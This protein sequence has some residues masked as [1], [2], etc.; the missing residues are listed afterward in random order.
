MSIVVSGSIASDHLMEFPGSFR[1]QLVE[2]HLEQISLSFL[3]DELTIRRGGIGANI[4]FGLG[5]LGLRP[6]LVGSVGSDFEDYREWLEQHGV[7]TRAVHVSD[8]RH[9]ARFLCTTD[10]DGNQIASFY[11]GAMTEAS[12][13]DL[14]SI[15]STVDDLDLIMISPDDP[16]AMLKYTAGCREHGLPFAADPSQQIARMDG[17]HLRE[18][19]D[20]AR[21]IFT[22]DYER[23]L[24]EQKTG[25]SSDEV[26]SQVGARVTTHG[27]KGVTVER[28]GAPTLSVS[29]AP[30][31]RKADPTGVG[32]ALR[33][34]FLAATL[35]G[36]S[37][38]RAAQVGC[39]M[40]TISLEAVG[41]QEYEFTPAGFLTRLGECYGADAADDVRPHLIGSV[42]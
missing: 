13:I 2:G 40:A 38:E 39:L 1:D 31:R 21:Y 27:A 14:V 18:L 32:D 42:G 29:A 3:V 37:E 34:G 35:W 11:A 6:V 10:R 28:S 15:A 22:N 4:G 24:L 9:T 19:I 8:T 36:L 25:W 26:L 7:D 33:A 17:E 12:Q 16:D 20:G 5:M 30:E 41:P 23:R